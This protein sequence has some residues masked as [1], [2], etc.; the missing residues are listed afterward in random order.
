MRSI[1]SLRASGE[2]V[3]DPKPARSG[4]VW[5]ASTCRPG[6][7]RR[8]VARW[9]PGAA[10][11]PARAR[12]PAPAPAVR[13]APW[14]CVSMPSRRPASAAP[15]AAAGLG[16]AGVRRRGW[17]RLRHVPAIP[18]SDHDLHI[19]QLLLELFDALTQRRIACRGSLARR[20]RPWAR[21]LPVE[22][23]RG[24]PGPAGKCHGERAERRRHQ[25]GD[26]AQGQPC[27]RAHE[28][29]FSF[30]VATAPA[31]TAATTRSRSRL[32][33]T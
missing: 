16:T 19:D 9:R 27:D 20:R 25:E 8:R 2:T 17:A 11:A 23:A 22:A 21:S 33:S 5:P 18:G 31:P 6:A 26:N 32:S 14:I 24:A 30:P 3:T 29:Y 28:A 1:S 12:A 13:R 4:W 10:P 15:K 7:A